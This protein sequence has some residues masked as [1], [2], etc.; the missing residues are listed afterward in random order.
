MYEQVDVF[1]INVLCWCFYISDVDECALKTDDCKERCV[2]TDGGFTCECFDSRARLSN[3]LR[4][5]IRK[6][7]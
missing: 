7:H 5:C 3:D 1:L 4:T 2:N 6:K